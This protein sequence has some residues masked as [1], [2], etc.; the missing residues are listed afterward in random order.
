MKIKIAMGRKVLSYCFLESLAV[1][2]YRHLAAAQVK[3]ILNP[4][5]FPGCHVGSLCLLCLTFLLH[6]P[7]LLSEEHCHTHEI[8]VSCSGNSRRLW[9]FWGKNRTKPGSWKSMR[10][11][12]LA[13][14]RQVIL[15]LRSWQWRLPHSCEAECEPSAFPSPNTI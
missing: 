12:E 5:S 8:L 10:S 15:L 9:N 3:M 6:L 2:L 7:S 14:G 13:T 4:K 1:D 11:S